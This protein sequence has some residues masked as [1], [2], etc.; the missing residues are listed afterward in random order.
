M[1]RQTLPNGDPF[2]SFAEVKLG[3]CFLSL[4]QSDRISIAIVVFDNLFLVTTA[5]RWHRRLSAKL[6][7]VFSGTDPIIGSPDAVLQ[8]CCRVS[9]SKKTL[10]ASKPIL[11]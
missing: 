4:L 9:V 10:T 3:N 8:L 7:C 5:F 2:F 1:A 6:G 11:F